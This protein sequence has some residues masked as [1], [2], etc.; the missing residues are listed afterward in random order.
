[1][2]GWACSLNGG[3]RKCVQNF[4]RNFFGKLPFGRLDEIWYNQNSVSEFC[5]QRIDL[6]IYLHI[7]LCQIQHPAMDKDHFV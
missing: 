6:F 5:Y 1:M 3:D 7:V 2:M 4:G